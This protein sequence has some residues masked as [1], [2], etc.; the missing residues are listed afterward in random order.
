MMLMPL[1]ARLVLVSTSAISTRR[2]PQQAPYLFRRAGERNWDQGLRS[3][4]V[5][6]GSTPSRCGWPSSGT[7]RSAL[8]RSTNTCARPLAPSTRPSSRAPFEAL[9]APESNILCFRYVGDGSVSGD[10]LD[11]LNLEL[12]TIYNREGDGWIT[13]TV[14]GGRRVLRVTVMN[15]ARPRDLQRV[16]DGW[17]LWVP[18]SSGRPDVRRQVRRLRRA[19]ALLVISPGAILTVV[20]ETAEHMGGGRAPDAGRSHE[21]HPGLPRRRLLL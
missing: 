16:L 21:R 10:R 4:P 7:A 20:V 15:P 19:V 8:A 14:L 17:S 5:R 13:S 12:R 1:T 2:S 18:V 11:A 3:S 9:H 6:A